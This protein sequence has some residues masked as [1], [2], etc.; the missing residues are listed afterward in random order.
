MVNK[1]KIIDKIKKYIDNNQ[2][3]M[4]TVGNFGEQQNALSDTNSVIVIHCVFIPQ[5]ERMSS[6][7]N[8]VFADTQEVTDLLTEI[9]DIVYPFY[10]ESVIS[11]EEYQKFK[12]LFSHDN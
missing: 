12:N 1:E 5:N 8:F 7:S 11:P 10:F 9:K 6:S 3:V 2:K 4:V